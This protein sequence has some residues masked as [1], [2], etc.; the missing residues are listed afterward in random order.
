[1]TTLQD[2]QL[3]IADSSAWIEMLR[4]RRSPSDT[5]LRAALN[6]PTV[7]VM[8]PEPVQAEVLIG[9]R[10][11]HDFQALRRLFATLPVVLLHA[12]TDFD[13]AV[14]LYRLCRSSGHMVRS[15][16][17]CLIVAMAQRVNAPVLH[18]DRDFVTLAAVSGITVAP[19]SLGA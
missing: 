6:D 18:H 4:D 10:T 15:L 13:L 17:D 9:T 2:P 16:H 1:M 11:V 14:D 5:A 7:E 8:V 3:L 19:G 12:R